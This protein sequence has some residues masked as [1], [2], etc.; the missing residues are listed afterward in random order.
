MSAT[1]YVA[2]GEMGPCSACRAVIPSG[3]IVFDEGSRSFCPVCAKT[4]I[5][6]EAYAREIGKIVKERLRR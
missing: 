2:E 1:A 3:V 6:P 4:H 5:A